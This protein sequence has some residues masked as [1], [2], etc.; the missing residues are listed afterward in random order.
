VSEV[1]RFAPQ[2]AESFRLN[3]P[4]APKLGAATAGF[5][6]LC[7]NILNRD[8]RPAFGEYFENLERHGACRSI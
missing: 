7:S 3:G 2:A 1:F 6:E 4:P 8:L 5:V